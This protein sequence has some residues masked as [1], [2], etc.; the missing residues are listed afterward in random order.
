ML[1]IL[2]GGREFHGL[3]WTSSS[4]LVGA[5][6]WSLLLAEGMDTDFPEGNNNNCIGYH[7]S[8]GRHYR[9]T[10]HICGCALETGWHLPLELLK[11]QERGSRD[12]RASC[13][14]G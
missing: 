2:W 10:T 7:M 1:S 13:A 14:V 8:Y 6:P 4:R 12:D 3:C 11:S 5:G 9:L